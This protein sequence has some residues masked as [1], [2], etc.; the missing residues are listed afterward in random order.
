MAMSKKDFIALA[1]DIKYHNSFEFNEPFTNGQIDM[2]ASFCKRQNSAFN[3]E[4][5][6]GYIAGT[7]GP[8]GGKIKTMVDQSERDRRAIARITGGRLP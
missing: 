1:D 7:N 4:R 2:L 6:H 3:R 5:W 8:S